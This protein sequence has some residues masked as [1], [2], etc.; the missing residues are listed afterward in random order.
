MFAVDSSRGL[1]L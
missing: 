1:Y